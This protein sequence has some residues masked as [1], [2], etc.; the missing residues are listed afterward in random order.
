MPVEAR[1]PAPA[2]FQTPEAA[3]RLKNRCFFDEGPV[4]EKF[5]EIA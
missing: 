5:T 3:K 1:M 4:H 2:P